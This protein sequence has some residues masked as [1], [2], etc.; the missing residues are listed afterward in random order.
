MG[1][2]WSENIRNSLKA[3]RK[4][5]IMEKELQEWYELHKYYHYC[6]YLTKDLAEYMQISPRTI[7]R[8]IKGKTNPNIR[9]LRLIK[10]YLSKKTEEAKKIENVP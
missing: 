2:F 8:W 3:F 10:R 9:E 1:Y 5:P 6:D 4:A 7:Q